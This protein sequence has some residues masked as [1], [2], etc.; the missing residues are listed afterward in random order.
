[1]SQAG[2]P[3]G[4]PVIM[5]G[6]CARCKQPMAEFATRYRCNNEE[7]VHHGAWVCAECCELRTTPFVPPQRMDNQQQAFW[8]RPE[9]IWGVGLTALFLYLIIGANF[10]W[11]FARNSWVWLMAIVALGFG[12]WRVYQARANAGR[13]TSGSAVTA[14]DLR[15]RWDPPRRCCTHCHTQMLQAR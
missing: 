14:H 6:A 8:D 2:Q 15:A 4:Q 5:R 12:S 1:M 7:C 9:T 13:W 11:C 3:Q 10:N